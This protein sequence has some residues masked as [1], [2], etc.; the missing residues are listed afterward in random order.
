MAR[1]FQNSG[2]KG[3]GKG[4]GRDAGDRGKGEKKE[5]KPQE[6]VVF[7]KGSSS[8]TKSAGK[9]YLDMLK[10]SNSQPAAPVVEK[11]A[12]TTEKEQ[13]TPEE[14]PELVAAPVVTKKATPETTP[15]QPKEPTPVEKVQTKPVVQQKKPIAS[16]PP[17]TVPATQAVVEKAPAT[18]VKVVKELLAEDEQ[19]IPSVVAETL[20]ADAPWDDLTAATSSKD[21]MKPKFAAPTT[22]TTSPTSVPVVPVQGAKMSKRFHEQ[23][24]SVVLPCGFEAPQAVANFSF[25]AADDRPV[26]P[27]M[28]HQPAIHPAATTSLQAQPPQPQ[29]QKPQVPAGNISGHSIHAHHHHQSQFDAMD[30]EQHHHQSQQPQQQQGRMHWGQGAQGQGGAPKAPGQAGFPKFSQGGVHPAVSQS[31]N[32]SQTQTQTQS[33]S[34]TQGQGQ[35]QP[36]PSNWSQHKTHQ[37]AQPLAMQLQQFGKSQQQ[38]QQPLIT[39]QQERLGNTEQP[40][41][42]D[43]RMPHQQ[44]PK[45]AMAGRSSGGKGQYGYPSPSQYSGSVC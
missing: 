39:P 27:P 5:E 36:P 37:S 20:L 32:P 22:P 23:S 19:E 3:K 40:R 2:G 41:L 33:Q 45:S 29:H 8:A 4:K 15:I 38:Q 9:S 35:S 43:Q 11:A 1:E 13:K 24:E 18:A 31:Q 34:Q 42:Y 25:R 30:K 6:K 28:A 7:I 10:T 12:P 21:D 44:Q 14:T 17:P 16:Q 26:P